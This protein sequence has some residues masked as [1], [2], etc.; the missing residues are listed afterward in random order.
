MN[1]RFQQGAG[2]LAAFFLLGLLGFIHAMQPAKLAATE[3]SERLAT[4]HLQRAAEALLARAANDDNRP[5]S[6]PCP[7]LLTQSSAMGN[8]PGDGKADLLT[9]NQCP[10]PLGLLPWATLALPQAHD[11]QGNSL[12]YLL[13]AALTDDD[14][15]QPLHASTSTQLQFGAESDI[16][17][18]I[19]AP[20]PPRAGQRRPG[21]DPAHYLE[22]DLIDEGGHRRYQPHPDS[23]DRILAISRQALQHAVG[24]RVAQQVRH[25][26]Q[27]HAKRRG[28][29]P[30]PAALGNTLAEGES[31]RRFGQIP[32]T[33]PSAGL[34]DEIR[35]ADDALHRSRPPNPQAQA[36]SVQ[37]ATIAELGDALSWHENLY[38]QIT[39]SSQEISERAGLAQSQL[40]TLW[41]ILDLAVANQRIAR[42]EGS[43][44]RNQG[45]LVLS[46]LAALLDALARLGLDG[47]EWATGSTA[48]SGRDDNLS[49]QRLD[50]AQIAF[51]DALLRFKQVDTA[52]PR[53]LQQALVPYAEALRT[54]TVDLPGELKIILEHALTANTEAMRGQQRRQSA[55][56]QLSA[57]SKAVNTSQ[58]PAN[59]NAI[60]DAWQDLNLALDALRLANAQQLQSAHSS[61]ARAWPLSWASADCNFLLPAS[62][63]WWQNNQWRDDIF[64][65]IS[66]ADTQQAG[67]LSSGQQTGLSL[68]VIAA[69]PPR[70]GQQR[71]SSL[72][73]D[74]LE[75]DLAGPSRQGQARN[76]GAHLQGCPQPASNPDCNDLLAF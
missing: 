3:L 44:L 43:S 37:L 64:Y 55:N 20:G 8:V 2:L 46:S 51:N 35:R 34:A 71:P 56:E 54:S 15:S 16:A 61:T 42:S 19:L 26:L 40:S 53:P 30:W 31:G 67:Q 73:A 62:T 6:L 52:N 59:S 9:R 21:F 14:S 58:S 32:L 33:Q 10:S 41:Q 66:D 7:D 74:Y 1:R 50:A 45:E 24:Q 18:L 25:C 38:N 11:R 23:N 57:T 49:Q 28:N 72:L 5:G 36:I 68:I 22:G 76:P 13:A 27:T 60:S 17:A 39:R 69:G 70:A 4:Q 63:S 29:Y 48:H 65:Q 75:N 12:W 47:Q